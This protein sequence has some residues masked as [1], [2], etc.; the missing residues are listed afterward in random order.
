M[1]QSPYAY[2][3]YS[4]IL[5]ARVRYRETVSLI[6]FHGLAYID[7]NVRSRTREKADGRVRLLSVAPRRLGEIKYLALRLNRLRH[8][9]R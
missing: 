6:P 7:Q 4:Q 9:Y 8:R 1:N 3:F 2:G 5:S